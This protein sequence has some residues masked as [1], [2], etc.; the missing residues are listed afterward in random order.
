M[1]L[2]IFDFEVFKYDILLGLYLIDNEDRTKKEL[3][4]TWN[5]D[6]IKKLYYLFKDDIWI[7]HNN[8]Y[9]DNH[10]L[11]AIIRDKNAYNVNKNIINNHLRKSY[12]NIPLYYFDL[13]EQ[14]PVKLKVT[15]CY[16]GKKI[17]ILNEVA[18]DIDRPLTEE[19]KRI[20]EKYNKSDLDQTYENFLMLQ[21]AFD[22]KLDLMKE[23]NLDY[24]ILQ[25]SISNISAKCLKVSRKD[26]LSEGVIP[27]FSQLKVKNQALLDWYLNKKWQKENFILTIKG[28]EHKI[29][30]GGIHGAINNWYSSEKIKENKNKPSKFMS[31]SDNTKSIWYFD[32]S[33][34]YNLIMINY[35]LFPRSMS[36][37]AKEAYTH[38]Y[39]EQLRLKKSD[40]KKRVIFKTVLLAVF[41][42]TFNKYTAFYDSFNSNLITLNGQLFLVDLLEKLE[43]YVSNII[44][45]NTDGL[46][47]ECPKVN[48]EKIIEIV[49]EWQ[50]RTGFTLKEERVKRIIQRDVNNY[51][52]LKDDGAV[53]ILGEALKHAKTYENPFGVQGGAFKNKE[54]II[55]S[56]ALKEALLNG[57]SPEETIEK[58]KDNLRLF[59]FIAKK[60]SFDKLVLNNNGVDEQ[61]QDICRVFP[62][63]EETNSTIYKIK[64]GKRNKIPLLPQHIFV[65]NKDIKTQE[66]IN[67]LQEKIDW[68]WYANRC[69][70][71]IDEFL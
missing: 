68:S 34:Y 29:G 54:P 46:F 39:F 35:D 49:K 43:P 26:N 23:F 56:I 21:P 66:V 31:T 58:Y 61:I 36:K 50:Q 22:L 10:I 57:I 63:I 55:I 11:E 41:G 62:S 25:E 17:D 70:E 51:M 67:K 60:E 53:E 28:V 3:Y 38:L 52:A 1:K 45:S 5:V 13:N 37:E 20:T 42:S 65:Y 64:Q 7:G 30:L 44:Q 69:Y 18:F 48:D 33:G 59:Q 47:I 16:F 4:Q 24:N 40:P 12:L 19:E 9:Y 14:V 32:V 6:D 2:I 27:L 8:K 15:E 71:R